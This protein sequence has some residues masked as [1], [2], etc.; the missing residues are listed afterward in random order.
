MLQI[1]EKDRHWWNIANDGILGGFD[2]E[3]KK[4]DPPAD[5]S[6]LHSQVNTTLHIPVVSTLAQH[7]PGL[8]PLTVD[9]S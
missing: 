7:Q 2:L 4:K 9:D 5:S 3:Q 1:L 8:I 6:T